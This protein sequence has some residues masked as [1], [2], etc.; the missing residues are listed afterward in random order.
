MPYENHNQVDYSPLRVRNVKGIVVDFD[1]AIIPAVCVARFDE[2]NHKFMSAVETNEK[3]EFALSGI[4]EG[5]YRLVAKYDGFS[6]ANVRVR[7]G[8]YPRQHK[9]RVK[10]R[11]SGI[12]TGSYVEIR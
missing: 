1:G 12:D 6:V 10:M 5:L 9:L 3:G 7:I 4:P 8:G 11:P 2:A